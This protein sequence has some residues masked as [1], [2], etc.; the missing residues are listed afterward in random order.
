MNRAASTFLC[1][2][3]IASGCR[4]PPPDPYEGLPPVE[5][6]EQ[7]PAKIPRQPEKPPESVCLS[8]ILVSWK[9]A[10][11]AYRR[12][13]LGRNGARLRAERLLVLARA[14]GTDF[15]ELARRFSDD[16]E[17]SVKDGDLGVVSRGQLHPAIE[18][19]GF[20]METGQV[21]GPIETP[22]GFHIIMR[23]EPTEFQAAEILVTYTGARKYKPKTPRDREQAKQLAEQ[24]LGRIRAGE[25]F[26]ELAR[27]YSDMHNSDKGGIYRI[28]RKGT[29][30]PKFEEIVT[31]L[32]VGQVSD[33][34]ETS[35]GF[36]IVKRLPVRRIEL[37]KIQ[38]DYVAGDL[39]AFEPGKRTRKE[40]QRL[41]YDIYRR[42]TEE[43]ADFAS[44]ATL[45]SE[46]NGSG[47][48]GDIGFV[49]R[50]ELA[51]PVEKLVFALE[52]GQVSEVIESGTAFLIFKRI[53]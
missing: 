38:I 21:A 5:N 14:R 9:G 52:P 46:G 17:T 31:G 33:V 35:T 19:A 20:S 25:D 2:V 24:L 32:A 42:I 6:L 15:G 49:G 12:I 18:R 37:R 23:T 30:H 44:M 43:G 45:Y 3:L 40:A 16:A 1:A 28:F 39:L 29:K 4:P 7:D 27:K 13:K 41:A 11:G 22:R 36:H 48:G 10:E 51:W 47:K 26:F 34:I 53:H 8:Q 50:G